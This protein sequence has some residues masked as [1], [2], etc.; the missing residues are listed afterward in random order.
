MVNMTIR[1]FLKIPNLRCTISILRYSQPF[2]WVIS[3]TST[4]KFPIDELFCGLFEGRQPVGELLKVN[5]APRRSTYHFGIL[6]ISN[7]LPVTML[8]MVANCILISIHKFSNRILPQRF[9]TRFRP[10]SL[11]CSSSSCGSS[12][13]QS[14]VSALCVSSFAY[15]EVTRHRTITSYVNKILRKETSFTGTWTTP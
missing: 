5:F 3:L 2:N 4:R 13:G 12:L 9:T 1:I 6:I 10:F 11:Y 14:S 7:H 8:K 15:W